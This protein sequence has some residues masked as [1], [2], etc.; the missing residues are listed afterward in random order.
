MIHL[1]KR[2]RKLGIGMAAFVAV[3]AVYGF[4]VKPTQDRIRTLERIIPEKQSEL[5]QV[6]DKSAEYVTLR[7]EFETIQAQI[8]EQDP[9][10]QLLPFVETLVEQ[11]NL[12]EHLGVMKQDPVQ[13]QPGYTETSVT[14]DLTGISL[15]QLVRFLQAVQDSEVVAQVGTLHI[16]KDRAQEGMLASTMQIVSPRLAANTVAANSSKP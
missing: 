7:R 4:A 1:T 12:T 14:I 5:E 6:R 10:F 8:A 11:H 2:E 3:W 16:R 9:T 15:A 13:S